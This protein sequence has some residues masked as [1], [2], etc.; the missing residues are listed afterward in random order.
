MNL[1]RLLDDHV[2]SFGD[3]KSTFFEGRWHTTGEALDR[4]KRFAA[5]LQELGVEPGDRVVVLLPNCPEVSISYWASWRIGAAVTPVIF[6]LPPPEIRRILENSEA[7]VAITSP[8]LLPSLKVAAEGIATLKH[9]VSVGGGDGTIPFE[10]VEKNGEAEMTERAPEDLAALL[11]TGGTTGSSK[12][13][14][15]SHNNL[16]WTARTAA[17]AS[18]IKPNETGLLSL[19]LSHSFGLHVSIVGSLQPG[20]GVLLRWFDP[21]QFLDMIEQHSVQRTAVVPA[22]LQFLLLMP[23][24]D[25]DLSS[26]QSITSGAAGLPQEVLRSFE[27]RVPGCG[28]LQGYGLTETSPTVAVQPPSSLEDGTRKIGSVGPVVPGVE[29]RIEGDQGAP[30]EPGEVGEITVRGPN[31]MLGYWRNEEATAEAIRDGWFHTG[32]MGRLDADGHLAIV[33]RKKDLVIRGGFNVF[34]GDV[35][36]VLVDHPDV[37][38]AAVVG[39]A[40]ET[41]GEEPVALVVLVPGTETTAEELDAFC[42]QNLAKYKRPAEIRIVT[43]IPK[44]PVGKPDKKAIRAA[45]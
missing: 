30:V 14:M 22:M 32:D 29:V 36:G 37:S 24:E 25:R 33:D 23:F 7:K 11:Y 43:E 4:T 5:G 34:P 1:A 2:A 26:L 12:G 18:E 3:Y 20:K 13:V 40:S 39:R 9:I 10:Q 45:L 19:P 38:E 27:E 21:N 8:D 17:E 41:W 44:T 42:E 28:I 15:L 16:E 6:L 35:E 31:V